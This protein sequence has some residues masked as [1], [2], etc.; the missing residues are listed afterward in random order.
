M[1]QSLIDDGVPAEQARRQARLRLGG[2][3]QIR[4][5]S[6]D[7]WSFGWI[8]GGFQDL[9]LASRTLRRRPV[10][11]TAAAATLALGIGASTAIFS[12]AYGVSLRPLPYPAPDRLLRIYEANPASHKLK[13]DVS[14]GAFQ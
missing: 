2:A 1:T 5:A 12:V 7:A 14:D 8:E 4:E 9:R 10:F 6:R 3:A 11:T 13:E